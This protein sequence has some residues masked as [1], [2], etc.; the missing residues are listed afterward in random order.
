MHCIKD[1]IIIIIKYSIFIY[2]HY[3]KH[4]EDDVECKYTTFAE[5]HVHMYLINEKLDGHHKVYN[6]PLECT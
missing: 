2:W 6:P 3:N 5:K 4:T 1:N